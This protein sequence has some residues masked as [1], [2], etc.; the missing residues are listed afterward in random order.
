MYLLECVFM[1]DHCMC[2]YVGSNPCRRFSLLSIAHPVERPLFQVQGLFEKTALFRGRF[3]E[4]SRVVALMF[5]V[6][7]L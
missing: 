6:F 7:V 2:T 4:E 1:L 5:L 3:L